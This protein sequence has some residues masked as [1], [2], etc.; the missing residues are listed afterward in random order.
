M[1]VHKKFEFTSRTSNSRYDWDTI[2][3][4]KARELTEGEDY[5]VT[6]DLMRHMTKLHAR[7]RGLDVKTQKVDG[8]LVIQAV[9]ATAEQIAEWNDKAESTK[10]RL[11]ERKAAARA[12]ANGEE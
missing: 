7:R 1:K 5:Q 2:L 6:T 3:D 11:K 4:G 10:A 12:A 8:G 9:P